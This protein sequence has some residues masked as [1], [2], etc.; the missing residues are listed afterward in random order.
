MIEDARKIPAGTTLDADLCLIGAGPAAITIALQMIGTPLQVILLVGG[1][2]KETTPYRD[3]YR[4]HV[5]PP[6]SH[7]PLEEN[8]PRVLG[9]GTTIWGA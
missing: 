7:E 2:R 8:R 5:D 6:S 1:A 9:G 3:L 4:G